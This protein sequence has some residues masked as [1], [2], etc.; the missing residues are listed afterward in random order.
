MMLIGV[1][2]HKSTHTATAVAPATNSDRGSIRI[3]ASF[4]GYRKLLAWAVQWPERTWAVEN[5]EGLGHHLAG[6]LVSKGEVVVDVAPAATARIRQL[7][8]GGRRKNDRIDAAA[9][10]SVAAMHGDARPVHAETTA[11]SLALLDERRKTLS[12]NRTRSV[13]QLHALLRELL[14]GGVP[15]DLTAAKAST[16]LRGPRPSTGTGKVR[17][18]LVKDLIADIKRYDAQLIDNTAAMSELLDVHGTTLRE[19][20]GVGPVLAARIVGRTGRASRFPTAAAYANYTGAAPVEIA[21]GDSTRHRLSRYGD[22]ELNSALHTIAMI[23]IRMRG[24]AGRAYYDK[25]IAEGKTPKEAKRCLKRR[26]ADLCWRT[27][28]RDERRTK[29]VELARQAEAA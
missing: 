12:E 14:P 10:A 3:D 15:T 29:P 26:L 11:D 18:S 24:S 16:V 23:Q 2:P 13:N 9:A 27:M 1:D 22:R 6:W 20:P 5:A 7:S 17:K 19:I 4:R 21:S 28:I 25:K 8:R